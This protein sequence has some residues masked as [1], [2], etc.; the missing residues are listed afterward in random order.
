MH[1]G[2]SNHPESAH[3]ERTNAFVP[4]IRVV[5]LAKLA[6]T[7]RLE[8]EPIA[9][10]EIDERAD[11]DRNH[12]RCKIIELKSANQQ[13]HQ[14]NVPDDRNQSIARIELRKPYQR[15]QRSISRTVGPGKT[16]MP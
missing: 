6:P 5:I 12:I 16:L 1:K 11:N 13:S 7:L 2:E 4:Y 8:H 10:Q 9:K 3:W 14:K 15:L